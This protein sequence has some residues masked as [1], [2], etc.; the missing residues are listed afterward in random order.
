[1]TNDCRAL[2]L[3]A[4]C[5]PVAFSGHVM[6]CGAVEKTARRSLL[7]LAFVLRRRGIAGSSAISFALSPR[8]RTFRRTKSPSGIGRPRTFFT[9]RGLPAWV[10]KTSPANSSGGLNSRKEHIF[11]TR[12]ASDSSSNRERC[13]NHLKGN[14]SC[15]SLGKPRCG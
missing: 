11:A 7:R 13:P 8:S 3:A 1:M 14:S 2:V 5:L 9:G 10:S 15:L 4:V 6:Y 12:G